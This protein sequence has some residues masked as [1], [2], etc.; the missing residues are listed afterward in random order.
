MYS[1]KIMYSKISVAKYRD[2]S[3]EHTVSTVA[4]HSKENLTILIDWWVSSAL[5]SIALQ[6]PAF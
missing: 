4:F 1:N 2:R 3:K 5:R 6:A